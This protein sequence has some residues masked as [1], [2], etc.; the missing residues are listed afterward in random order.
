MCHWR[1]VQNT[2]KRCGH[3]FDLPDEMVQ[4]EN[5]YCKFSA[6]HPSTCVPPKCIETCWQ[7]RQFPQQYT[8]TCRSPN[9]YPLSSV[10]AKGNVP[11]NTGFDLIMVASM[12]LST[13]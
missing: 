9:Q 5:R 4:C 2:Y 13:R 3:V 8:V 7:Y 6:M 12:A 11:I 10:H 1:R